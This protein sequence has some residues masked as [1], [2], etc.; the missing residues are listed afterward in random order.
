MVLYIE[1]MGDKLTI[2]FQDSPLSWQ[3]A[4]AELFCEPKPWDCEWRG[5]PVMIWQSPGQV[6]TTFRMIYSQEMARLKYV[7]TRVHINQH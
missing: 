1:S 7:M 6:V 2:L 4:Y 5:R 3:P